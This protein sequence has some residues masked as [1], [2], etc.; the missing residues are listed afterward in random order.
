[1]LPATPTQGGESLPEDFIGFD[2]APDKLLDG[3]A[4]RV[5]YRCSRRCHLALEVVVS[6]WRK[7][8]LV[9]F[10][11]SWVTSTP[12][13]YGLW[14]VV[15][16]L[17]PSISYGHDFSNRNVLEVDNAT[18]RA[19]LDLGDGTRP[20]TYR[21]SVL[22]TCKALRVPAL[23]ERPRQR[24]TEC[25]SWSARLMWQMSGNT[26]H[27]CP[28]EAGQERKHVVTSACH[29]RPDFCRSACPQTPPT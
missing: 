24:P 12:Q 7:T 22:S 9:V 16:T 21:G 10:R 28:H 6:V 29:S 14:E 5:G 26:V 19:W 13:V 18:V 2:S 25:P 20:S 17:P 4:V 3:S 11:R 23:S 1:M 15:L 8:E 27:Q